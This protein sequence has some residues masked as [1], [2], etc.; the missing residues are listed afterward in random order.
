MEG[1]AGVSDAASDGGYRVNLMGSGPEAVDVVAFSFTYPSAIWT[2]IG[3]RRSVMETGGAVTGVD[4]A[5]DHPFDQQLAVTVVGG[6]PYGPLVPDLEFLDGSN[7]ISASAAI[8]MMGPTWYLTTPAMT[9]PIDAL[10]RVV[11]VA[12]PP[13]SANCL[14]SDPHGWVEALARAPQDAVSVTLLAPTVL[15]AP[16]LGGW[17]NAPATAGS[18]RLAWTTDP[19]AQSVAFAFRSAS[20]TPPINWT[21]VAAAKRGSY[22]LPALRVPVLPSGMLP[23]DGYSLEVI[24]HSSSAARAFD[25]AY[26]P[27]SLSVF[28]AGDHREHH[29][30]GSFS[31][32]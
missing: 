11:H 31:V 1:R 12:P 8:R 3:M 6:D 22:A 32:Q 26:G 25:D 19:A 29:W 5:L 7:A 21:V 13:C 23:Q 30:F 20:V 18:V 14:S 24:T 27:Q 17:P 2:R 9:A 10:V 16:Q 4:V 15:T 28:D